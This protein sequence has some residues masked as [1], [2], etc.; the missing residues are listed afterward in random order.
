MKRRR[1]SSPSAVPQNTSNSTDDF[2]GYSH[3]GVSKLRRAFSEPPESHTTAELGGAL[4][5]TLAPTCSRP[6]RPTVV[7]NSQE[8]ERHYALYHTFV[9]STAEGCCSVFPDA[10]F[11]A[12][13]QTEC[14]D[15]LTAIRKDRGEKTF[16]CFLDSCARKFL[17]PKARRLH[18][19]SAHGY[20]KEFFF[21]ITNKG[22]GGLMR[23]WGEGVSLIRGEW[24]GRDGVADE[25]V[26][27]ETVPNS[28]DPPFIRNPPPHL[29][30]VYSTPPATK[31]PP[32]PPRT[33]GRT[34]N[35][36]A[37]PKLDTL[38]LVPTSIRFGR[39]A[40]QRGFAPRPAKDVY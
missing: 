33:E 13:H 22:I 14:H 30:K 28:V 18:L 21:A 35:Q 17:T 10:R 24:Q 25:E 3:P 5:C 2:V 1:D 31:R 12:L 27:R 16:E 40:K 11:L 29:D 36:T 20:A 38:S 26:S 39:G 37:L 34:P 4:T 19:I 8:M 9:C 6:N 7:R 23:K 15:P 32:H